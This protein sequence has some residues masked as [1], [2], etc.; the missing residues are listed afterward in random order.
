LPLVFTA[1]VTSKGLQVGDAL[2]IALAHDLIV[3]GVM[4]A[5]KSTPVVATVT[6]V[7]D[8]GRAGLPGVLTFAVHSVTLNNG[9]TL[10]LSGTRTKEGLPR[11]QAANCPYLL[12]V[13]GLFIRGE[14]ADILP[15]TP[16]TAVVR[17]D[18]GLQA[19]AI[20]GSQ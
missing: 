18:P 16:L 1:P 7:D 14:D 3:G 12:P 4:L 17:S 8:R 6:Q 11:A 5:A 13:R 2:P 15:G 9:S 20:A 19:K 10:F